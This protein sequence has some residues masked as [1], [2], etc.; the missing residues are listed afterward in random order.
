MTPEEWAE[1]AKLKMD[2]V[3]ECDLRYGS[4]E[5]TESWDDTEDEDEVLFDV[6]EDE[7]REDDE[8]D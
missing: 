8:D 7:E 4:L 5:A 6:D 3:K 1:L 2:A